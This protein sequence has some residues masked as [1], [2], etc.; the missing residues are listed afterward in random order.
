MNAVL[1]K[2][3]TQKILAGGTPNKEPHHAAA[4]VVWVIS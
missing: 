2:A 1:A 4:F 3:L